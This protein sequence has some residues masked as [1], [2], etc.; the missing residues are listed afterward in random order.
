MWSDE[1]DATAFVCIVVKPLLHA[2]DPVQKRLPVR[3]LPS[4]ATSATEPSVQRTSEFRIVTPTER[5]ILA[6][7]D[8]DHY[9]VMCVNRTTGILEWYDS[10]GRAPSPQFL[11]STALGVLVKS[12][13]SM[14][15]P[16]GDE[17]IC[18]CSL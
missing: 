7:H 1:N 18:R 9:G 17:F 4:A 11:V 5:V 15:S 14:C 6:W 3:L 12:L 2:C 16:F 10:L 8:V 13:A